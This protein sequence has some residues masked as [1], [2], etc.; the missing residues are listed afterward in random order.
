MVII[1][2]VLLG[3][4]VCVCVVFCFFFFFQAEDGIR[5]VAVTGVQTCALPIWLVSAVQAVAL[6]FLASVGQV[7]LVPVHNSAMSHSPAAAR[8]SAPAFPAGCWQVVL[9]PSHWSRVQGLPSSAQVAPALPAGCVQVLL[10]P[11][12]WS[13]VQG[14]ASA[15]QAVPSVFLGSGGQGALV[16]AQ[17]SAR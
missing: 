9:L 13:R 14:L 12:H 4:Q 6:V 1:C 15:V 11:S 10:V 17:G 5:D 3:L 8:Q 16:P 7:A 2:R